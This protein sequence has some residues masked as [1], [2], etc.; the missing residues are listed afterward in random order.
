ML[1]FHNKI[2]NG[3]SLNELKK[4]PDKSFD[5]VFADPPYNMQLGETLRSPDASK[6]KG[7]DDQCDQFE[8]FTHSDNFSKS[9]LIECK[10]IL[11]DH[12]SHWVIGS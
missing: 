8:R 9:R 3:D 6:V 1:S 5:L 10:R 12:E 7:V 2:I 4:I 11:K